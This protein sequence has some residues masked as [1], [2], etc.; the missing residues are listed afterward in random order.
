MMARLSC[1]NQRSSEQDGQENSTDMWSRIITA[2]YLSG[3]GA[4]HIW[5]PIAC[6]GIGSQPVARMF[7]FCPWNAVE[8]S[9]PTRVILVRVFKTRIRENAKVGFRF[10]IEKTTRQISV[11]HA[12]KPMV[13]WITCIFTYRRSG[14]PKLTCSWVRPISEPGPL[15]W[16]MLITISAARAWGQT[17]YGEERR[18]H[19]SFRNLGIYPCA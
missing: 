18:V 4:P 15:A 16:R 1:P 3:Q 19:F 2:S 13:V 7:L 8:N 10:R 12:C 17:R 9:I 11:T 6:L 5:I 14:M